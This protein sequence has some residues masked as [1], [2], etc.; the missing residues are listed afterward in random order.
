MFQA[1]W[2]QSIPVVVSNCHWNVHT[3][4]W[5]PESFSAEFGDLVID[6]IDCTRN[7]VVSGHKMRHFW[8]GLECIQDHLCDQKNQPMILKLKD[9]PPNKNFA[10]SL[11]SRFDDL[12][13]ALP[14][15]EYTDRKG[16][17]NMASPVC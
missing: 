12:L 5:L 1:H 6:L 13:G 14:L 9:W 8:D 17:F 15:P 16:V 3:S 11:P 10:D 4:L 2:T 7:Q